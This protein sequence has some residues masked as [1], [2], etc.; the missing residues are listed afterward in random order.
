M[1]FVFCLISV[2]SAAEI[3]ASLE[4]DKGNL[5]GLLDGQSIVWSGAKERPAQ[6]QLRISVPP[7]QRLERIELESKSQN[8]W[9]FIS[10][11]ELSGIKDGK[12]L[13]LEEKS[14]YIR[15]KDESD[16]I[17]SES[18]SFELKDEWSD[19]QLTLFRPH[20]FIH[21]ELSRMRLVFSNQI[22]I[23]TSTNWTAYRIGQN[24]RGK[25]T[26]TANC[27]V[28]LDGAVELYKVAGNSRV[29]KVSLPVTIATGTTVF[30]FEFKLDK[31]ESNFKLEPVLKFATLPHPAPAISIDPS[32]EIQIKPIR[33][34]YWMPI[35]TAH[36]SEQSAALGF[37]VRHDWGGPE[38]W[39]DSQFREVLGQGLVRSN[40]N[41]NFK[42]DDPNPWMINAD[43]ETV[44]RQ[45][46]HV[47][48]Y[49]DEAQVDA[50]KRFDG[51]PGLFEIVYY[52]E[53]G[54]HTW[55]VKGLCDYNPATLAL[56]RRWLESQY[57]KIAKLNQTYSSEWKSFAEVEPPKQFSGAS[58]AW[59][60]W[61]EFRRFSY[62]EYLKEAYRLVKPLL[63]Q[64]RITPKPINFDYYIASTANDPWLYRDACD[65]FGYDVYPFQREGYLDPAMSLDFHRTQVG[66]KDIHFLETNFEF[67]RPNMTEKTAADMLL[68]YWPAFL[69]GLKG[70]Y[71]YCWYQ[72][73]SENHRG[74]WLREPDGTLTP[75]GEGAALVAKTVQSLA[76]VLKSGHVLG[77]KVAIYFPWEDISQ[78]PNTAPVNAL[79]GAYK[80]MTQL[81]YPVDIIS[82]H[83]ILEGDLSRYKALVM[84]MS[85]HLRPEV[86]ER[87]CSF[88]REGGLLIADSTCGRFDQYHRRNDAL[89]PL[90][91]VNFQTFNDQRE[92]FRLKDSDSFIKITA[93]IT[94]ESPFG[95]RNKFNIAPIP[96]TETVQISSDAVVFGTFDDNSPA[97]ISR[98]CERGATLY[99]AST[100]FNSYRNYFYSLCTPP[101]PA[102]RGNELINVGDRNCRSIVGNFLRQHNV[103]PPAEVEL[104]SKDIETDN[105]PYQILSLYG[106]EHAVLFGIANWGPQSPHQVKTWIDLP[107]E[108]VSKLYRFD[109]L[110]EKV[111]EIPFILKG[112]RLETTIP[113]LRAVQLLLI[114]NDRGPL[115]AWAEQKNDASS[116]NIKLVNH[117]LETA[118]G[119]IEI[120]IDGDPSPISDS[121]QFELSSSSELKVEIPLHHVDPKRLFDL[122]GELRPCYAWITYDGDARTFARVQPAVTH[123]PIQ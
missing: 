113:W 5:S 86:A 71:F 66:K 33:S 72:G 6:V 116:V 121:I 95:W 64:T 15:N 24:C 29:K 84:P 10:K 90:F 46:Y 75:Q 112:K 67:R 82:W 96:R 50:L 47:P 19:L 108:H 109:T 53:H 13:I 44:K 115:L 63:P 62:G 80:M 87:I 21:M 2:V 39:L 11:V 106:D 119:K 111:E 102:T 12:S 1:S 105:S 73:W 100:F 91:G 28:A 49:L 83:N 26:V 30:P 107:F 94:K 120:R 104:G 122:R 40:C 110:T 27:R 89:A 74:F 4:P 57:G 118:K 45:S 101:S 81:H 117:L 52:N 36:G 60:D 78:I 68:L 92:G 88:V 56:Y 93:P 114:V 79:Y 41:L 98:N 22:D 35:G 70:A 7:G 85:G 99:F 17:I 38:K 34:R 25:L 54:Y 3:T 42:T 16:S 123:S 76:P 51:H 61:M 103:L 59:F 58:P 23:K 65:V 55:H 8:R 14:W 97:V 43:G 37:N 18:L 48:R 32:A 9:W 77:I 69:R 31:D 20:S